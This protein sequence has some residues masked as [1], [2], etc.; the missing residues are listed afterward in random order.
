MK[1]KFLMAVLLICVV[2]VFV[3]GLVVPKFS[4]MAKI[5]TGILRRQIQ[6]EIAG[7][8]SHDWAGEYYAG[9]GL[10]MNVNLLIAPEH[11]YVFE[12]HGCLGLYDRNYGSVTST[13]GRLRLS[14]T[15]NNRQEGFEGISGEFIPVHWGER[16]YLVPTSDIVGFCNEVNDGSEP[17]DR[18]HGRYLM[19]RGDQTKSA[20][21]NAALPV[22]FQVYL[23]KQPVT[24]AIMQ[25][26]QTTTRPDSSDFK[27]K[28]TTVMINAGMQQGLHPGMKLYVT[29]PDFLVENVKLMNVTDGESE[30]FIT[31]FGGGDPAPQVGWK[32]STR[33]PWRTE[34]NST[35]AK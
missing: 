25:V 24:A 16:R 2:A 7:A 18:I 29:E 11:G 4:L 8:G 28:D 19:R 22:E 5:K 34:S 10:G 3:Y 21:S 33:A 27:I 26:G 23:L 35:V 12:W 9:D 30:G 1:R 17:R 31:Q 20:T 32:L 14:F 6:R 15:F 13:N